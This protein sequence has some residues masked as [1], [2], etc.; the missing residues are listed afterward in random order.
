MQPSISAGRPLRLHAQP[1]GSAQPPPTVWS[2]CFPEAV[3]T[4]PPPT[5]WPTFCPAAAGPWRQQWSSLRSPLKQ[6]HA[7][8]GAA[9]TALPAALSAARPGCVPGGAADTSSSPSESEK[10]AGAETSSVAAGEA[11]DRKEAA[12]GAEAATAAT[13]AV[14]AAAATAAVA[15][16][17]AVKAAGP[18]GGGWRMLRTSARMWNLEVEVTRARTVAPRRDASKGRR[19]WRGKGIGGQGRSWV[20]KHGSGREEECA[21]RDSEAGQSEG[22]WFR[23]CVGERRV[24]LYMPGLPNDEMGE[25]EGAPVR[26]TFH[27]LRAKPL[28]CARASR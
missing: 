9:G 3:V 22:G 25:A 14:E 21:E 20:G 28:P 27:A 8:S 4:Q 2:T 19:T 7:G 24:E 18:G 1:A 12:V 15:A 5:G 26:M 10:A 11:A 6:A 23:M 16:A 17:R 13:A